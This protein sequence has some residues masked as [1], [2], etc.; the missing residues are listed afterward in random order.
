MSRFKSTGRAQRGRTVPSVPAGLAHVS[1]RERPALAS[2]FQLSC[3]SYGTSS[4]HPL[5]TYLMSTFLPLQEHQPHEAKI[6]IL[7]F[8]PLCPR[9][10]G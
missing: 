3:L 9:Y 1:S 4:Q 5:Q 2:R 6:F 8:S 7:F 10:L